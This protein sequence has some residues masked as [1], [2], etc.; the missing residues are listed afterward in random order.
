MISPSAEAEQVF[1]SLT[2]MPLPPTDT[3]VRQKRVR[4]RSDHAQGHGAGA[5]GATRKGTEGARGREGGE[6]R[7]R[8]R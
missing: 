7:R 8:S 1:S 6:A 3:A 5:G 2:G 4:S